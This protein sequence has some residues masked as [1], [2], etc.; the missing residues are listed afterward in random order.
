M[1]KQTSSRKTTKLHCPFPYSS[2]D[3]DIFH[4]SP[5]DS[6]SKDPWMFSFYY[7]GDS[8]QLYDGEGQPYRNLEPFI[9]K[10]KFYRK[11]KLES[12]LEI[13]RSRFPELEIQKLNSALEKWLSIYTP[14]KELFDRSID[15]QNPTGTPES[16]TLLNNST[17]DAFREWSEAL[18][19]W[20]KIVSPRWND[21]R[22]CSAL[23]YRW[24]SQELALAN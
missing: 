4:P 2:I 24:Y 15:D 17:S 9:L 5:S 20:Q 13:Y 1:V 12:A 14:A 10:V 23:I 3:L 6:D 11:L 19:N 22:H 8:V 16:Q 18:S 7:E 21:L